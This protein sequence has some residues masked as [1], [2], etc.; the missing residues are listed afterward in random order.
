[1]TILILFQLA[2]NQGNLKKYRGKKA[3]TLNMLITN[4]PK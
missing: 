2:K 4:L 3:F 1:M